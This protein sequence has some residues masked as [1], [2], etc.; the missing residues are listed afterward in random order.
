MGHKRTHAVQ[1]ST[2]IFDHLIGGHEQRL[3]Q[4]QAELS[5]TL[6][7]KSFLES[8]LMRAPKYE[9]SPCRDQGEA[10]AIVPG[11]DL[12][13]LDNGKDGEN[14]ERN[15]LLNSLELSGGIDGAAVTVGRH[16]KTIFDEGHRPTDQ[17]DR[18][19]RHLFEA[20]VPVP[21]GGHKILEPSSSRIG[22]RYGTGLAL[23]AP[24]HL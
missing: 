24:R 19:K 14:Y 18:E 8:L 15:D 22:G 3:R 12:F 23:G 20:Q 6:K 11:D 7:P 17:Y 13:Q 2:L 16:R 9:K 5:G 21:G 4:C 1:Q 10:D